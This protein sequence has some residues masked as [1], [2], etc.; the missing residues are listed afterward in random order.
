MYDS[1]PS[2]QGGAL[3]AKQAAA[4]LSIAQSTF[5]RWVAEGKLPKGKKIGL[6]C[7]VWLKDELAQWLANAGQ[8]AG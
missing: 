8:A 6:R 1:I 4:F 3:R 2:F 7:T 5:W